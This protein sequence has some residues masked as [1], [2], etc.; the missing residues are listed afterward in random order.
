MQLALIIF[1]VVIL[2]VVLL[3]VFWKTTG[4]D[5]TLKSAVADKC[6]GKSQRIHYDISSNRVRGG[7]SCENVLRTIH[8]N[9]SNIKSDSNSYEGDISCN[10]C[11]IPEDANFTIGP[12]KGNGTSARKEYE[13]KP[14]SMYGECKVSGKTYDA[15]NNILYEITNCTTNVTGTNLRFGYATNIVRNYNFTNLD[16]SPI[17]STYY[18]NDDGDIRGFE[19]NPDTIICKKVNGDIIKF[20]VMAPADYILTLDDKGNKV[21][22]HGRDMT[23]NRDGIIIV[24]SAYTLIIKIIDFV[25][26]AATAQVS[27]ELRDTKKDALIGSSVYTLSL[28]S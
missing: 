9:I 14:A 3:A 8:P 11:S 7:K 16:N 27:L 4:K 15:S 28:S 12:C 22:Y 21:Y 6:D 19:V 17:T 10:N 18:Y 2:V 25:K 5:C 26:G 24:N 23:L 13:F 20:N 1:L